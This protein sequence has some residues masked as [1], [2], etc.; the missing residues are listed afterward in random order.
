[1]AYIPAY[2]GNVAKAEPAKKQSEQAI[3]NEMPVKQG[4]SGLW[5]INVTVRSDAEIER[6]ASINHSVKINIAEDLRSASVSLKDTVDR[7]LVPCSDF[8]L[9][10]RD[11]AMHVPTAI[12]TSTPS[13][14]TAVSIKVLPDLRS[15]NVKERV[16][17]EIRQRIKDFK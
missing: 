8:V 7:S 15:A 6:L 5:D 13:G 1:M 17:K 14:H 16:E 2:M 11:T 9:L 3:A 10:I 12:Q 4:F